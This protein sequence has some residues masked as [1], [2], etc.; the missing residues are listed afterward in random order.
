MASCNCS[1]GLCVCVSVCVSLIDWVQD[2]ASIVI[3]YCVNCEF[4]IL[5]APP[6]GN[7]ML[8]PQCTVHCNTVVGAIACNFNYFL[9]CFFVSFMQFMS[10]F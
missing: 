8:L 5:S 3:L 10:S 9:F 2:L 7:H 6:C 4:S 1:I